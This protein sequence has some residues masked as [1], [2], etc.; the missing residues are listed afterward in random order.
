VGR[1]EWLACGVILAA[2]LAGV[3]LAST[4]SSAIPW[5]VSRASGIGAF[6]ALSVSVVLGLLVST[7][8]VEPSVPRIFS[9][10]LHGFMSV[11]ALTLVAVHGGALLF[12][13]TFHYTVLQLAVPFTTDYAPFATGL[14]VIATWAM[15]VVTASFWAKAKIGHRTWRRLHYAS[16]GAYVLS[17]AHGIAAGSDTTNPF[18][19]WMYAISAMAVVALLVLRLGGHQRAPRPAGAAIRGGST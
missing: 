17:F 2:F 5:Y 6:V 8:A 7:K 10:E 15:A 1:N 4:A 18:V 16:F 9:F 13:A 12:D 14:G 19:Y 3:G 11:L